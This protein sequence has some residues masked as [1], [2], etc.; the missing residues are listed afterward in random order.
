[1]NLCV[2]ATVGQ[3]GIYGEL[4]KLETVDS[5]SLS[6][7]RIHNSIHMYMFCKTKSISKIPNGP[8]KHITCYIPF[9]FENIQSKF[10]DMHTINGTTQS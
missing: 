6:Y 3:W 8:Y 1:M 2:G 5:S 10:L 4:V 7:G 9:P